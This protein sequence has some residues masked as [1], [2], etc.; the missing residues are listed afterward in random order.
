L[1][2]SPKRVISTSGAT[3][4]VSNL[5]PLDSRVV[6]RALRP[7]RVGLVALACLCGLLGVISS[8]AHAS[9]TLY[10]VGTPRA[11]DASGLGEPATTALHGYHLTYFTHFPGSRLPRG[12]SSFSGVPG[13]TV[14]DVFSPAHVVVYQGVLRLKTYQDPR[15]Q[16]RWIT[17][18]VCQCARPFTYGA[19][20]V[21]S[22]VTGPGP[23]SAELLW[24][25]SNVWP[26]EID[27]YED[28]A[29]PDLA[30]Q[31]VHWGPPHRMETYQLRHFNVDAW[32][33]WGVIW[34][35]RSI[36]F[37]VDGYGWHRVDSP[38]PIPHVPMDVNIEQRTSCGT[39]NACPTSPQSLLVDWVAVYQ[40]TSPKH[41]RK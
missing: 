41:S 9:S 26:P 14:G 36:T 27:F 4:R 3:S 18:G 17:A 10:P 2:S 1:I 21:R 32:H 20:F 30:T 12:W 15:Y 6:R 5:I 16:N 40:P 25:H 23:N 33:T 35:P 19:V 11:G 24:P 7:L 28:L 34:T 31:S 39:H 22:R 13:G 8:S 37:T 29:Q 38:T